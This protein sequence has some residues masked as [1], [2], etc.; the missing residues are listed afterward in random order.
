MKNK[1]YFLLI[2]AILLSVGWISFSKNK[3]YKANN[4]S[5]VLNKSI[6]VSAVSNE[7]PKH[8]LVFFDQKTFFEG[9]EKAKKINKQ[10]FSSNKSAAYKITGGIIPHDL[11]VGF[12][13][14]DFFNRLSWQK[15]A[16]I[17]L[18]GPNHYE[19]GNFKALTSLYGWD[20]PYG[21]VKPDEFIINSLVNH[22][23]IHVDEQT[24]PNDHAVAGSMSFIKYYMPEAK[25]V[26]I[27]LSGTMTENDSEKLADNLKD[28]IKEN[29]VIIAPVDFS[30]YLT[31]QHAK[32][33]DEITLN[34][35][36]NFDYRQL[37]SFNNDYLDS[38]PSIGTL[39]MVMQ[40]LNITN[41]DLLDHNN[42]G[43]IQKNE[44]IQTTSFFEIAYYK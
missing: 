30:H 34:V 8:P 3:L 18:L 44:Y 17:I 23:L 11:D 42:T 10:S 13:L 40:K 25:V 14:A 28:F 20:T 9:I 35:L 12:V 24:L 41:M 16:T 26:P 15:P 37:F 27:L 5:S 39:L 1:K 31:N 36:K 2:T 29:V 21:V 4:L 43:E 22:N 32:Q 33:K 19:K 7:Q 6:I 38:P